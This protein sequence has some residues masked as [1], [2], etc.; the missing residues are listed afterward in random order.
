MSAKW[1]NVSRFRFSKGYLVFAAL[2][3]SSPCNSNDIYMFGVGGDSCVSFVA[4]VMISPGKPVDRFALDDRQALQSTIYREWL[5]GFISGH[6]ATLND[7]TQRVQV[8][9]DAV[10]RYVRWWCG[11][12]RT[13][14]ISMAVQRFL[15]GADP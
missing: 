15:N 14:N 10:D 4:N 7:P 11:Q 6:N 13:S 12:N 5:L 3:C 1:I 9:P 2:C 8:D